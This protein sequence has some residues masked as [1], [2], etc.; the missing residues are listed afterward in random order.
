VGE[1]LRTH[2]G[3]EVKTEGDGFVLAFLLARRALQCAVA[4]QWE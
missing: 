2:N 3:Y 1:W 4:V